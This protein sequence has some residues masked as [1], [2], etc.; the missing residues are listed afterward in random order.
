LWLDRN[1]I[2]VI[3]PKA[4]E[5]LTKLKWIGL[6]INKI[7]TLSYRLFENNPHL[8]Y[9]SF[10]VNYIDSIHPNF[11]DGLEELKLVDFKN[12]GCIDKE[13]GCTT[14]Q[15]TQEDL[16]RELQ[17][18]YENCTEGTICH[19]SYLDPDIF[20]IKEIEKVDEAENPKGFFHKLSKWLIFI[21]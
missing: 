10:Y 11:F 20:Q 14:C 6:D 15:M 17:N 4:F 8:I 7:Q 21:F 5:H 9:I 3:E 12:N 2:E 1:D 19:N 16:N 13:L 18:C